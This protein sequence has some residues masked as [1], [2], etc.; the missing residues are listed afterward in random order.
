MRHGPQGPGRKA[1]E[2]D[3][4]EVGD[5]GGTANRGEVALVSVA[6]RVWHRAASN[7]AS[8]SLPT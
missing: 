8:I 3:P 7:R 1:A 2:L 6:E 5:R 4:A